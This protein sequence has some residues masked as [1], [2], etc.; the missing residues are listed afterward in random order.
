MLRK[1]ALL[2]QVG[3]EADTRF[4]KIDVLS[5]EEKDQIRYEQAHKWY[6]SASNFFFAL[7]RGAVGKRS[8]YSP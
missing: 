5:A 2:S 3:G 8:Y 7:W 1:G 4:E 6:A